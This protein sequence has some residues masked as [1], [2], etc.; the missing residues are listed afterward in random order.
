[1]RTTTPLATGLAVLMLAVAALPVSAADGPTSPEP[2]LVPDSAPSAIDWLL[3]QNADSGTL[4]PAAA[5]SYQ[6]VLQG[7]HEDTVAFSD[8]PYREVE[9]MPTAEVTDVIAS[10]ENKPNAALQVGSP[11]PV[12]VVLTL[13]SA[14]YDAD[15]GTLTYD[16]E[17]LSDGALGEL[18]PEGE[19]PTDRFTD[20]T[21]FIDGE[22]VSESTKWLDF[23]VGSVCSGGPETTGPSG[24]PQGA[25]KCWQAEPGGENWPPTYSSITVTFKNL[26]EVAGEVSSGAPIFGCGTKHGIDAGKTLTLTFHHKNTICAAN[27]QTDVDLSIEIA[28]IKQND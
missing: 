4:V 17:L 10:A 11:S 3:V 18:A 7:V 12:T 9:S 8:T 1:M 22:Q 26:G 27:V 6:L 25:T 14:T 16:V 19:A 5:G 21:L 28:S 23:T 24:L 2:S 15:A 20:P 13:D